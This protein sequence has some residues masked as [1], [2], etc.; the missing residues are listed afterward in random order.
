MPEISNRESRITTLASILVAIMTMIVTMITLT[1]NRINLNIDSNFSRIYIS[2]ILLSVASIFALLIIQSLKRH[3][4][5]KDALFDISREIDTEP[6]KGIIEYER[7]ARKL[8]DVDVLNAWM[9]YKKLG[10]FYANIQ[11]NELSVLYY[12]KAIAAFPSI[13]QDKDA[14]GELYILRGGVLKRL[15]VDSFAEALSSIEK[16]LILVSDD[17]LKGDAYYNMACIYAKLNEKEKFNDIMMQKI[18]RLNEKEIQNVKHRIE[19]L[20]A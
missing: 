3:I 17:H 14:R 11:K 13:N 2:V 4:R 5:V 10:A 16:G 7:L 6:Q 1:D 19:T 18:P 20:V 8:E 12:A 9:A 15:G